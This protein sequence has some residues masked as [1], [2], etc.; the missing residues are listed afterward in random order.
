MTALTTVLALV[1]RRHGIS[2]THVR[3]EPYFCCAEGLVPAK[4]QC[5]ELAAAPQEG[6]QPVV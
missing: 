2:V 5:K 4:S 3:H 1:L 6:F